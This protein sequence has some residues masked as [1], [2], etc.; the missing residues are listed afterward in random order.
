MQLCVVFGSY[1]PLGNIVLTWNDL[2]VEIVIYE[3]LRGI[4]HDFMD[5]CALREGYANGQTHIFCNR[6]DG[7]VK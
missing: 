4:M 6:S 2:Y 7:G 1:A 5:L 3:C